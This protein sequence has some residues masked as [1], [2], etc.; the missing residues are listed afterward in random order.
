MNIEYGQGTQNS[1]TLAQRLLPLPL[2]AKLSMSFLLHGRAEAIYLIP[3][4]CE[5]KL[6]TWPAIQ[7]NSY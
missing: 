4:I 3:D 5:L 7:P 2:G 6:F 1:I